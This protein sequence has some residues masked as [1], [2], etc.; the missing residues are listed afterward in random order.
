MFFYN[1][2]NSL[3]II[4]SPTSAI[5]HRTVYMTFIILEENSLF[6]LA[7]CISRENYLFIFVMN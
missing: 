1:I 2:N 6:I 3:I 5:T 4:A 7:H